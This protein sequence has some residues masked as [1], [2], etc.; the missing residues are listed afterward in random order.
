M[1]LAE[2][3]NRLGL[4]LSGSQN[5]FHHPTSHCITTALPVPPSVASFVLP[6][7]RYSTSQ[8]PARKLI[9]RW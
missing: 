2:K 4:H 9:P 5:D 1:K 6:V 7:L 8:L 3:Q